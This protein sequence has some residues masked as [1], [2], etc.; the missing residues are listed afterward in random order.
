MLSAVALVCALGAC[1][2]TN[3]EAKPVVTGLEEQAGNE[4]VDFH[5]SGVADLNAGQ[6]GLALRNFRLALRRNPAAVKTL[7]GIAVTYDQIGRFDV[8]RRYFERALLLDPDS[9]QTLN[10]LGH[11]LLRQGR[12]DLASKYLQRAQRLA[13]NNPVVQAN[14][15]FAQAQAETRN[16]SASREAR[17]AVSAAEQAPASWIERTTTRIQ[18]LVTK[19]SSRQIAPTAGPAVEPRAVSFRG[20]ADETATVARRPAALRP[21]TLPSSSVHPTAKRRRGIV[22]ISNGVGRRRMAGRM[23]GYLAGRGLRV[24]RLTNAHSFTYVRTVIFYR[25]GFESQAKRLAEMLP[26]APM[27]QVHN[28]PS[29]DIRMILGRDLTTFDR[30]FLSSSQ[31]EV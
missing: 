8:S 19:P 14:M 1:T 9:T 13:E 4:A 17:I 24:D 31:R 6:F 22:E 29:S 10:N 26:V 20:R 15:R 18:T 30:A 11:S 16:R 28:L 7:N 3:F 27:L 2:V 12:T 5:E 23:R 21:R 25:P